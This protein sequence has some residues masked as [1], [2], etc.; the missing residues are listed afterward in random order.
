MEF[1]PAQLGVAE[2]YKLLIGGIVPRPIAWVS[3]ISSE[4]TT[5]LAPFSFFTGVGSDPMSLLFCPANAADGEEKDTLRNAKPVEEGGQGEFVVNIVSNPQAEVMA[6]TAEALGPEES[7]AERFGVAMVP[8]SVVAPL[9]VAD[10]KVHY[11]CRTSRILRLNP[12]EPGGGNVVVAEVVHVHLA[13]TVLGER[14]HVDPSELDAIGRMGGFAYARTRDRF[15][16]HPG[17]RGA[18]KDRRGEL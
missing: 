13:D 11:E 1:D 2:R 12:G 9:R 18:E 4:G 10:S 8:S 16:I 17:I 14:L 5:N 7:E 15:E 6:A 3:T